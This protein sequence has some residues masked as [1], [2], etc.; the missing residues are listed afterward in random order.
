MMPFF[1]FA[2][3]IRLL[4]F[5]TIILLL[6]DLAH[7][8]QSPALEPWTRHKRDLIEIEAEAP[9]PTVVYRGGWARSPKYLKQVGG[10]YSKGREMQLRG[11]ALTP[12]ELYRGSSL[13]HSAN[14][15]A[16][17]VTRYVATS[18]DPRPALEF[19]TDKLDTWRAGY[20]YVIKADEKM[21][22]VNKSLGRFSPY[23]ADRLQA[24]MGYIPF[25]QIEG[26][27]KVNYEN[28]FSSPEAIA[29]TV[30]R[31]RNRSPKGYT[32]NK[33]FNS[34]RYGA[35][36]GRG[37]VPKLAGFPKGHPA[38]KEEKWR[39]F[40][41]ESVEV[42][43]DR[44]ARIVCGAHAAKRD[45]SCLERFEHEQGAIQG[46]DTGIEDAGKE[47]EISAESVV[48]EESH[49]LAEL[50]VVA[51][52]ISDEWFAAMATKAGY[53]AVVETK[54]RASLSDVRTR[55]LGYQKLSGTPSK[56]GLK[57]LS[58]AL[59][60]GAGAVAAVGVGFWINDIV[61]T[62]TTE[63]SA[64]D[65]GAVLTRLVPIIG[66]EVNAIANIDNGAKVAYETVDMAV[67][68]LADA[69][70]LGGV[71]APLG[72]ALHLA[73]YIMRLVQPT[74]ALPLISEIE[75]MRD[76]PWKTFIDQNLT[77]IMTSQSW[78]DKLEGAII[79]ESLG[80]TSQAA[81]A[82]S[83]IMI[84]DNSQALDDD[85]SYRKVLAAMA[86]V[87]EQAMVEI[88]RRQ[89]QF[90]LGLPKLLRD[91]L[92]HW[93]NKTAEQYNENFI[94][95]LNSDEMIKKYPTFNLNMLISDE[96]QYGKA[97]SYM[98][99][100]SHLLRRDVPELP[101]LIALAY[102]V[103]VAAGVNGSLL[104][105]DFSG[106]VERTHIVAPT[107]IDPA[108]YLKEKYGWVADIELVQHGLAVVRWLRGEIEQVDLPGSHRLSLS[109]LEEFR[110]LLAMHIGVVFA[111]WKWTNR[112]KLGRIPSEYV[113]DEAGLIQRLFGISRWSAA[114]HIAR[115]A[116]E[117]KAQCQMLKMELI[118]RDFLTRMAI[119]ARDIFKTSLEVSL[120]HW[121]GSA[122][123]MR[124]ALPAFFGNDA[125]SSKNCIK[126]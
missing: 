30:E 36:R 57:T 113:Q 49:A 56:L 17:G 102:Y 42:N 116:Q 24:A 3:L 92:D 118:E 68:L 59:K 6:L 89:R 109:E 51:D 98:S 75:E 47:E 103:G 90:L 85:D 106:P 123:A 119:L 52:R 82:S 33:K 67:C 114:S 5:S 84:N 31:I 21:I 96:E 95:M 32:R 55:I 66:C 27:Y 48:S 7:G 16:I 117:T 13:F 1:T 35:E 8:S 37:G 81:D 108:A 22:D 104:S 78:R 112:L 10:I 50:P 58:P 61:E 71:T 73:R 86:Q 19:A 105:S 63:T 101:G 11:Q 53:A 23:F 80:I 124:A 69:L 2:S 87:R 107:V 121:T 41:D 120:S 64:W 122:T 88:V 28:H 115:V 45:L 94:Q 91:G 12:D 40:K 46:E 97:R 74:P 14:G 77:L 26:W 4:A 29:K 93:M 18:S 62:F 125:A 38:W 72:I 43:L 83:V 54:W 100:A 15:N 39:A 126:W 9:G 76:T 20:V 34:A 44:A 25:D 70:L 110:I 60:V 99:W 111:D 79:I 65:K